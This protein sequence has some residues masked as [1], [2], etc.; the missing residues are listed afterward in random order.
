MKVT[1]LA[2]ALGLSL[3]TVAVIAGKGPTAQ[4]VILNTTAHVD[5][6]G[7]LELT[8]IGMNFGTAEPWVFLAEI[9]AT[10]VVSHT[11]TTI[12]A[13]FSPAPASGTY[14]LSIMGHDPGGKKGK[15]KKSQRSLGTFDVTLGAGSGSQGPQ[16]IPGPQGPQ[17]PGGLLDQ[18][19][20]NAILARLDVVEQLSFRYLPQGDGTVLDTATGLFWLQDAAC[21]GL[22]AF[23]Q[24]RVLVAGLDATQCNLSDGSSAGEWR[25]ATDAEWVASM[26]AARAL[27]C[28]RDGSQSPPSLTDVSGLLCLVDGTPPFNGPFAPPTQATYWAEGHVGF[29]LNFTADLLTGDLAMP[30]TTSSQGVWPVR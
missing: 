29:G 12:V 3:L 13:T 21:L 17:G 16:G 5:A 1:R 18:A 27:G 22:A 9:P 20:L 24:A 4:L 28:T 15:K 8:I 23:D 6:L 25:L 30:H 2:L 14:L 11:D 10:T 26:A 7:D 19:T